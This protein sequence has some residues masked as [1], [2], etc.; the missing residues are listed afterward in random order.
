MSK[1]LLFSV[2]IVTL[3]AASSVFSGIT[4]KISGSVKDAET[5][6]PLP[7]MNIVISGTTIGTASDINGNYYILNV[8]PGVYTLEA[9]MIGYKKILSTDVWVKIDRTILVDFDLELTTIAGEEVTVVAEREIVPMD[10]S[11]SLNTAV[12]EKII[13]VPAVR[14]VAQF[15][16]SQVGIES[17]VD[18]ENLVIRGGGMNQTGLMVDGLSQVD[19]RRNAPTLSS[20]NLSA[21]KEVSIL[22]GGFNAEYGNIRSGM[23]NVVTKEGGQRYHGSVD[24]RYSPSAMKHFGPSWYSQD[25]Y[26]QR[27]YVDPAICWDGTDSGAWSE[28]MQR[29]YP[30]FK[31]WNKQAEDYNSGKPENEQV[32]AQD[33]RNVFMWRH[34]TEGGPRPLEDGK[35]PDHYVDGSFGGP[36]PFIGKYLGDLSFFVSGR[37]NKE[38]FPYSL[39]RDAFEEGNYTLKLTSNITPSIKLRFSGGHTDILSAAYHN[40]I[41]LYYRDPNVLLRIIPFPRPGSGWKNTMYANANLSGFDLNRDYWGADFTHTLS[42]STFYEIKVNQVISSYNSQPLAPRNTS[43]I[44]N[45]GNFPVDETPLGHDDANIEA[46]F[47][48]MRWSAWQGAEHDSSKVTTTTV[49]ADI[50]S[51]I[52]KS[53]QV[54]AG[55]ELI[56]DNY[57]IKRMWGIEAAVSDKQYWDYDNT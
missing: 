12:A 42:P 45:F 28:E 11:S 46:G 36:V 40:S 10:V 55:V 2:F 51:Q 30:S 9:S 7:G 53:N 49:R 32:T 5:G 21:I 3:F 27:P 16:G 22:T 35:D 33:L 24:Y 34:F 6:A 20:V 29:Q 37:F 56:F 38:M 54:K 31:G 19:R 41:A 8:P 23:I 48:G 1:K 15:L 14:D 50:V 57:D 47:D 17:G 18:N 52:N 39:S 25:F 43:V 4:G 44:R 13:A 26:F